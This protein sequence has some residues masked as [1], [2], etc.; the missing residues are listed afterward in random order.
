MNAEYYLSVFA[1]KVFNEPHEHSHLT[2]FELRPY[3]EQEENPTPSLL[4]SWLNPPPSDAGE[5]KVE[6][7][8]RVGVGDGHR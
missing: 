3:L 5:D 8:G 4:K 6:A 1:C 7:Q 2:R